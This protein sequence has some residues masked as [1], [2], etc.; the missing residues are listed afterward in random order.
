MK[1]KKEYEFRKNPLLRILLGDPKTLLYDID[2]LFEEWITCYL[3]NS[4][5]LFYEKDLQ[6]IVTITDTRKIAFK[7][8][9]SLNLLESEILS[10]CDEYKNQD[11]IIDEYTSFHSHE[12]IEQAIQSLLDKNLLLSYQNCIL[13]IALTQPPATPPKAEEFPC[14]WISID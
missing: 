4:A 11:Q 7:E 13:N 9:Y 3:E 14:G 12:A 6:G 1:K 10:Y 2:K 8:K 5:L